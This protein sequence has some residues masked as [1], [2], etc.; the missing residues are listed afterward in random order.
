MR[1]IEYAVQVS[2]D[3]HMLRR[4]SFLINSVTLSTYPVRKM[5]KVCVSGF[6]CDT[7]ELAVW[8]ICIILLAT[9]CF[10]FI[11]YHISPSFSPRLS[12]PS[13]LLGFFKEHLAAM[14]FC[15]GL[16]QRKTWG[17]DKTSQQLINLT[18]SPP[19]GQGCELQSVKMTE[20]LQNYLSLLIK[21]TSM[22]E[23]IWFSSL[24][25]LHSSCEITQQHYTHLTAPFG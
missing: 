15:N 21:K 1:C 18:H 12:A 23:N 7:T 13:K 5:E 25:A 17:Q 3:A 24:A 14:T 4:E 19:T 22:T 2:N 20:G 11:L 6:A 10:S 16:S 9:T 8:F